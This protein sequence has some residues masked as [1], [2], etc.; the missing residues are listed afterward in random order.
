MLCGVAQ[1]VAPRS[2]SCK[3][4]CALRACPNDPGAPRRHAVCACAVLLLAKLPTLSLALTSRACV[5][6]PSG[7]WM[8]C[9]LCVCAPSACHEPI[10]PGPLR[11]STVCLRKP[12]FHCFSCCLAAI[13]CSQASREPSILIDACACY[14]LHLLSRLLF[15]QYRA[16][17]LGPGCLATCGNRPYTVSYGLCVLP[18]HCRVE[19]SWVVTIECFTLIRP[20]VAGLGA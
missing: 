8:D 2:H 5:P 15:I 19:A 1:T 13:H 12:P 9:V 11:W 16:A 6:A 4:S 17:L 14:H 10:P 18:G 7:M 3:T 20:I